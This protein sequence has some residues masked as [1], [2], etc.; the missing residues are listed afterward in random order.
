MLGKQSIQQPL[1]TVEVGRFQSA[2]GFF[3]VEQPAT[4]AQI[5]QAEGSCDGQPLASCHGDCRA[6][7]HQ[8][9]ISMLTQGKHDGGPFADI[10]V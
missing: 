2:D 1:S 10:E 6:I 7:V 8:D 9:Q 5:E 4:G 3:H